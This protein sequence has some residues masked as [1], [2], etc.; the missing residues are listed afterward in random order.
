MTDRR[1]RVIL[2]PEGL[3]VDV[4][5][6][7]ALL[8]AIRE[9]G[10][11]MET[12]CGGQGQCGKC[13]VRIGG[14]TAPAPRDADRRR[15]SEYE[16]A[17]GWRLACGLTVQG[18][19]T[20]EVPARSRAWEQQILTD[21]LERGIALRPRVRRMSVSPPPAA[22]SDPRSDVERLQAA[23]GEGGLGD[24]PFKSLAGLQGAAEALAGSGAAGFSDPG[25][26]ADNAVT[27]IWDD[28]GILS[29]APGR[30][31]GPL[32]GVAFDLGTTT[33]V[34]MLVDLETGRQLAVAARGNP[35][36]AFGDDVISR[37]QRCREDPAALGALGR[38]AVEC[39][40]AILAELCEK[41]DLA[42][43]R[44]CEVV[45]AGNTTMTH[46]L[47]GVSP[48]RLAL[49]PF[50]GV[51]RQAGSV[52]AATL[53]LGVHSDAAVRHLPCI[54]GFVG[55]DTTA[56][57]LAA[58]LCD[59]D[60]PALLIDLGTNGEIVLGDRRRL[61]ACSTAAGPAFEGAR[62]GQGMRAAIGAIDRVW[63][64]D[65]DL[66]VSVIGGGAA[67]GLCGA[68]LVDAVAA[69]LD[70]GAIDM[71]GRILAP[72]DIAED[73]GPAIR[74]RIA[75]DGVAGYCV[76]LTAPESSESGRPV[77]LTQSDVREFQLAKA[78]IMAGVHVLC[79]ELGIAPRNI[80][81]TLLAGAFG[82]AIHPES[83][84]R[85]GLIPPQSIDQIQAIGDAAGAGA[86]MALL[87]EDV[88]V[89]AEAV[90][91]S[92]EHIEL[93]TRRDFQNA[94][95]TWMMFDGG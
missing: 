52:G 57:I 77:W 31:S 42:P 72:E 79:D 85:V 24:R 32:C 33:V 75:P 88:R 23:T 76:A 8:A 18:P 78:A 43:E 20:V 90:A 61:L 16:L 64:E 27:V 5:R 30:Q 2:Q 4:A 73:A 93:S 81:Q 14:G 65:D 48:A 13:G 68:G 83:A 19:M 40:N 50:V 63:L 94:F 89:Q 39:L 26:S 41:T 45:V 87:S 11:L 74:R 69:L 37:I 34:G 1:D 58:G 38:L 56:A 46:L 10:V 47:L 36:T 17:D 44:I 80:T 25:A 60:E 71:G 22:L 67:R 12:P 70:G 62:I 82:N 66:Q 55:G 92:V 51:F 59:R 29:V 15:F 86:R 6:G 91:R 95:M 84:L 35:Q 21:G 28:D 53:G 9:G 7:T 54:A 3:H 49:A